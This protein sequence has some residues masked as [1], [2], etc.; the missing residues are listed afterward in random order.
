M[1]IIA[2]CG[3]EI[4]DNDEKYSIALAGYNRQGEQV[5]KYIVAC[6]D[7]QE[8]YRR[9]GDLLETKAAEKEWLSTDEKKHG[10]ENSD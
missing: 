7:C 6:L 1:T 8:L 4:P 9:W 3:H 2:T 10:I 5:V